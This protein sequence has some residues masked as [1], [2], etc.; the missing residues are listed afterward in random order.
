[1]SVRVIDVWR[2][3]RDLHANQPDDV[4]HGVGERVKAVG[5]HADRSGDV[6]EGDFRDGDDEIEKEDAVEDAGDG[7]V[8]IH[9]ITTYTTRTSQIDAE[10]RRRAGRNQ[11]RNHETTKFT[12][13]RTRQNQVLVFRVLFVFPWRRSWQSQRLNA[14][15]N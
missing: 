14:L 12:K 13:P 6:P 9:R 15:M 10:S 8:A 4:R 7:R 3:T 11:K 1:M 5:Q 2:T